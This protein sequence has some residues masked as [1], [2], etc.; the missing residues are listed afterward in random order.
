MAH[1]PLLADEAEV[2]DGGVKNEVGLTGPVN[3]I[4][5]WASGT[6]GVTF[7]SRLI[8]TSCW[9]ASCSAMRNQPG[10]PGAGN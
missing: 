2:G 10:E 9:L 7:Q 4:P 8:S 5:A 1:P 6:W 3:A